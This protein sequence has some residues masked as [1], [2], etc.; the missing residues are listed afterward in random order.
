MKGVSDGYS[1]LVGFLGLL[2][3]LDTRLLMVTFRV[4]RN[5]VSAD[6]ICGPLWWSCSDALWKSFST[7]SGIAGKTFKNPLEK[8]QELITQLVNTQPSPEDGMIALEGQEIS[9]PFLS[10]AIGM[11]VDGSEADLI[12][13]T[14]EKDIE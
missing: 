9:N 4:Y 10:K 2:A 13:K 5:W 12:K 8:P 6:R 11:L 7:L 1:Y 14:L 3:S